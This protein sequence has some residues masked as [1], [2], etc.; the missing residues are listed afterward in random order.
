MTDELIN[1]GGKVRNASGGQTDIRWRVDLGQVQYPND[2]PHV[3]AE[4]ARRIEI[5]E[6]IQRKIRPYHKR[7]ARKPKPDLERVPEAYVYE[8]KRAPY[9]VV[10]IW[11]LSEGGEILACDTDPMGLGGCDRVRAHAPSDAIW[12][13]T[14]RFESDKPA[15]ETVP[16][17]VDAARVIARRRLGRDASDSAIYSEARR[18]PDSCRFVVFPS[19]RVTVRDE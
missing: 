19:Q 3:V 7:A 14:H 13:E 5:L 6:Q 12:T 10:R 8:G 15:P 18:V 2:H 1:R 16:I 11:Y 4:R 9:L 17:P